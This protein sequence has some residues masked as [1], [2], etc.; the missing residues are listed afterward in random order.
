[1]KK[2]QKFIITDKESEINIYLEAGWKII[3]VT[4][5]HVSISTADND[6]HSIRG[7]FAVV[8]EEQ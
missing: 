2:Q 4:P 6:C 5:Q 8:I 3:S 1:M 7:K